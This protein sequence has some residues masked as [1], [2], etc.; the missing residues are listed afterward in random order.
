MV[1]RCFTPCQ[2]YITSLGKPEVEQFIP[3]E[4]LSRRQLNEWSL[5]DFL[6]DL[7]KESSANITV[8]DDSM[9]RIAGSAMSVGLVKSYLDGVLSPVSENCHVNETT[10]LPFKRARLETASTVNEEDGATGEERF[11]ESYDDVEG[12]L[13]SLKHEEENKAMPSLVSSHNE[14]K[15]IVDVVTSLPETSE[16]FAAKLGYSKDLYALAVKKLGKRADRNDLLN[17]LVKL[18]NSAKELNDDRYNDTKDRRRSSCSTVNPKQLRPIIID[19]SN[20]AMR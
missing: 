4:Q 20:V 1:F 8:I 15:D 10:E 6:F 9:V 11:P 14:P 13:G 16:D 2:E 3:V 18:K 5:A 17:E 7:E 12:L 19:G